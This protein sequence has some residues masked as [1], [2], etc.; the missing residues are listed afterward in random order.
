MKK[1]KYDLSIIELG[2]EMQTFF[3][4]DVMALFYNK[5]ES[6]WLGMQDV[7][8]RIEWRYDWSPTN[9]DAIPLK[10]RRNLLQILFKQ[11]EFAAR[12]TDFMNE[13]Y[14]R[15]YCGLRSLLGQEKA[16]KV[17]EGKWYYDIYICSFEDYIS[18]V[19]VVR[20]FMIWHQ[21][22]L[23][24]SS[25]E[26]MLLRKCLVK[27]LPEISPDDGAFATALMCKKAGLRQKLHVVDAK[28][29]RILA[30]IIQEEN[31]TAKENS[32]DISSKLLAELW[33]QIDIKKE[34]LECL[35]LAEAYQIWQ[36]EFPLL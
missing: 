36:A 14:N 34:L 9:F 12:D 8:G 30:R 3:F 24:V 13:F 32:S 19:T 21:I 15:I 25:D 10:T 4:F 26:K 6:A 16:R 5:C 22:G 33:H 23:P 20:E 17:E 27:L 2:L 28:C 31:N 11:E 18:P 1:Q 29:R 35:A 7:G